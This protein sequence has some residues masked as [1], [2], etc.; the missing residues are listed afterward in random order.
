MEKQAPKYGQ[1]SHSIFHNIAG[2][3][4]KRWVVIVNIELDY[5]LHSKQHTDEEIVGKC[6]NY[7]NTPKPS[8][9]GKKRKRRLPY[10]S[11]EQIYKYSI[12]Q[13][14]CGTKYIQAC[15]V[16]QKRKNKHFRGEGEKLSNGR[17]R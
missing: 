4:I 13:D 9:Y 16:V 11:F 8:K 1:Y 17:R 2:F 14:D 5:E 6:V 7:L 10:G 3:G 12:K 15:L